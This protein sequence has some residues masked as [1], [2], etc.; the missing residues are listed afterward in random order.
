MRIHVPAHERK[1]TS[2]I[3][4]DTKQLGGSSNLS[5]DFVLS[6]VLLALF[7]AVL[8]LKIT[9]LRLSVLLL[10]L[11]FLLLLL[12]LLLLLQLLIVV[13]AGRCRC[14]SCRCECC[15]LRL[16]RSKEDAKTDDMFL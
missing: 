1:S 15:D 11:L 2:R 13:A 12:L 8:K 9:T 7:V 4:E 6:S 5:E 3:E 14:R 16:H 10:M